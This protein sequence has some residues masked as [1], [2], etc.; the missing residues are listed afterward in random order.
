MNA[1]HK[2]IDKI[3]AWRPVLFGIIR[4]WVEDLWPGST[5]EDE[6]KQPLLKIAGSL[7]GEPMNAEQI[8][9]ELYD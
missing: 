1:L 9:A 3:L 5:Q 2:L 7:S 6:A 4:H 8:E